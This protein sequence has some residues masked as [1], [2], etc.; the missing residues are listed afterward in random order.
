M[1]TLVLTKEKGLVYNIL[2]IKNIKNY[3]LGKK[4]CDLGHTYPFLK[5]RLILLK[6]DR[7]SA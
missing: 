7:A 4:K 3:A 5:R 6:L 2:A 1:L